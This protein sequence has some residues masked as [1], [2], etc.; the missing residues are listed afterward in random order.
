MAKSYTAKDITVLEGLEPVRKRPAMYIGGVGKDGYH[1]LLAEVVDN[2]IDEAMNGHASV[3]EVTLSKDRR[4]ISV[5]DDGRGIPV[6]M[7][8]KVGKRAVTVILTTLHAGGKFE[9]KN[10]VH[11]GGLHGVGASVVNALSESL[12]VEVIRDDARWTQ[13]F[14]RGREQGDVKR[15]AA[16]G[17]KTGTTISFTPDPQ[18]FGKRLRFDPERIKK[19]LDDRSFVHR[20]VKLVFKD[21]ATGEELVLRQRKGIVALLERAIGLQKVS[22]AIPTPFELE[23]D[24]PEGPIARI[25]VVLTWTDATDERV[26]SYVNGVHTPSGGTHVNGFRGGVVKAVKNYLDTHSKLLPKSLKVTTE[27]IREGLMGIVSVFMAEPQFQGQT[28]ARLNN[29]EATSALESNLYPALETWLNTHT[30]VAEAIV[31]RI[32]MAARAREMSRAAAQAVR[33]KGKSRKRGSLPDKM[34]DCASNTPEECEL[35]IVEGDS[36][37]GSAKQGRDRKTQAVLPLRGKVLNAEQASLKKVLETRELADIVKALGCGLGEG[38]DLEKLNYHKVILLMD[39]DADGDHITTLL[40]TF[41]FRHLPQLIHAGHLYVARPPL[42]KIELGKDVYWAANEKER[43]QVLK[44]H[45]KN[46]TPRISRFKGLGE[47]M[48]KT[49]AETTLKPGNRILQR[50][51]VPS[52]FRADKAIRDLMGKDARPRFDFIMAEAARV[53]DLDV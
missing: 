50:V 53:Q 3:V 38:F 42:F 44:K 30:T 28:K 46:R 11:S 51:Q 19:D 24:D 20:G 9:A 2:S 7:H 34:T 37:G 26:R 14:V 16:K 45:R 49:L 12:E 10:Y 31:G 4:S 22:T 33:K 29:P 41:F 40:L 8:P 23:K 39:A 5:R 1:H 35:F 18:I 15:K 36:A 43:D 48:P 21:E 17:E 52:P 27:D 13:R 25:Q 6:D 32:A 47:M